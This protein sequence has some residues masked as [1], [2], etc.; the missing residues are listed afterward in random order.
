MRGKSI[1]RVAGPLAPRKMNDLGSL[2]RWG[3]GAYPG[4]VLGRHAREVEPDAGLTSAAHSA[5]ASTAARMTSVD[6]A[7]HEITAKAPDRLGRVIKIGH[8]A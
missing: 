5:S 2:T 7:C 1:R 8:A 4:V 6:G 3:G